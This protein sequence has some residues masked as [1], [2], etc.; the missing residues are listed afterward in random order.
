MLDLGYLLWHEN[1]ANDGGGPM[2][3]PIV[4]ASKKHRKPLSEL[5]LPDSR[6]RQNPHHQKKKLRAKNSSDIKFQTHV[7]GFAGSL[8]L[9]PPPPGLKLPASPTSQQCPADRWA[10]VD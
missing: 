4:K 8:A 6:F 5:L 2:V 9:L 7:R 3:L 10:V 1:A